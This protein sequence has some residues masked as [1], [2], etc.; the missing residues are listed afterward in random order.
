MIL[1]AF[2]A[3]GALAGDVR[4]SVRSEETPRA[5]PVEAARAPYFQ[6]WNGFIEPKKAT[7]DYAREVSVVLVALE[8]TQGTRDAAVVTLQNGTLTPSTVVV[9]QGTALRIRNQDDFAHRLVC[10]KVKGFDAVITSAGQSR[11]LPMLETGHFQVTDEF[12]PHVRGYLHVL[13]KVS[14]VTNPQADGGFTFKDV[15]SGKY[16]LIVYRGE[17]E[18]S[19]SEIEVTGSHSVDVDPI[20]VELKSAK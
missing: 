1:S 5:K 18:V 8:G 11:E 20:S 12:A 2:M 9:Q 10:P 4:G 6:E 19:S 14:A 16:A 17:A 13:A 7:L 3:S 15:P